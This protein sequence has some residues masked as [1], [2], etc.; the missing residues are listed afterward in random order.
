M[1]LRL[2]TLSS[3]LPW[4]RQDLFAASNQIPEEPDNLVF[5]GFE[6]GEEIMEGF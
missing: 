2:C 5:D 3:R 6:S 1:M 4:P